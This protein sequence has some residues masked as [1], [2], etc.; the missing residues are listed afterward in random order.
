MGKA[1]RERRRRAE[2]K[3]GLEVVEDERVAP[4]KIGM[5]H[6]GE[7]QAM[8]D[9]GRDSDCEISECRS[10]A[11]ERIEVEGRDRWVCGYHGILVRRQLRREAQ[12]QETIAA[13]SAPLEAMREARKRRTIEAYRRDHPA[14]RLVVPKK[15]DLLIPVP[16][17]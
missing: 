4:G 11:L 12:E 1:A 9:L 2:E 8:I 17:S 14:S 6:S 16:P 13:L 10:L 5:I 7:V 15:G 3:F